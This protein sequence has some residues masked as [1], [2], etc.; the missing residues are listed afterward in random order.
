MYLVGISAVQPYYFETTAVFKGDKKEVSYCY[1]DHLNA[2]PGFWQQSGGCGVRIDSRR[3]L[4]NFQA[5]T[6]MC[7]DYKIGSGN[8]LLQWT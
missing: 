3:P 2:N 6:M 4:L 7:S 1:H 5:S 8:A